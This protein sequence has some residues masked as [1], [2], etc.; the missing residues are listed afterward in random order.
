M[1]SV[2]P[3]EGLPYL[4]DWMLRHTGSDPPNLVFTLW[5]NDIVPE[6]DTVFA[7]LDRAT[8]VGFTE[9]VML[10]SGWTDPVMVGDNAV[11]T[12][13]VAPFEW[14][15]AANPEVIYGWA[16]YHPGSL[17]LVIVERFDVAREPGVGDTIGVL[18]RFALGTYVPCP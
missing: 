11:S 15:V 6:Q 3:N 9:R 5:T 2:I 12:W 16:A 1:P 18:P 10:R 7:D 17:K 13:G 8:F 4:L 14:V